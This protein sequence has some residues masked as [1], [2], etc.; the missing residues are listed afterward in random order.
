MT[1]EEVLYYIGPHPLG[2]QTDTSS[3]PVR[4]W[5]AQLEVGGGHVSEASSVFAAP[6]P[7]LTLMLE[8]RFLS[9]RQWC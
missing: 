4:N 5:A 9:D 7:S 6:L 1:H 8:F 3:W 2:P